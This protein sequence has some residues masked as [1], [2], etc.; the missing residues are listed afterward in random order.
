[1]GPDK[2]RHFGFLKIVGIVVV[3][4]VVV[5]LAIPFLI[6]ANQFRPKLESELTGALGRQVKVGNLKL[7]LLSGNIAADDIAI[8]DDPRFS[9]SPFVLARS[10][11]VGVEVKPLIVSR[12]LRIT[13]ITLDKPEITLIRST[14]GAWNVSGIGSGKPAARPSGE[15][16]PASAA[17]VSVGR[18][19]VTGGR[20]TVVRGGE[21]GKR[22]LRLR[23]PDPC[24]MLGKPRL[25]ELLGGGQGGRARPQK[26]FADYVYRET[27]R[28][29]AS[30]N[31]KTKIYSGIGFDV[32]GSPPEDP[33]KIYEAT[34]KAFEAGSG[35]I[36]VSRE[37]EEMRVPNL[38]AVGRAVHELEKRRAS[39]QGA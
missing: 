30:A 29:V 12:E 3:L 38:K 16:G 27:K 19:K 26:F 32:P 2:K 35:G 21:R 18:L 4:L 24:G 23:K 15:A 22:S 36:V 7:S 14:S 1:M 20:I 5:V 8:A 33:E 11:Q 34:L 39:R 28:S 9:S 13:G 25:Q 6:D 17:Q 10:L 37:Y 31:G